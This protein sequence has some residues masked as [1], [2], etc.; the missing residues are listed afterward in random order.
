MFN[1]R[2]SPGDWQQEDLFD[3]D[4][5]ALDAI[6]DL[7]RLSLFCRDNR[8]DVFHKIDAAFLTSAT[9]ALFMLAGRAFETQRRMAARAEARDL[10]CVPAA[11][12]TFD[13]ALRR[14]GCAARRFDSGTRNHATAGFSGRVARFAGREIPTHASILAGVP[15]PN[16][17]VEREC[18]LDVNTGRAYR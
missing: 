8:S 4:G 1:Q 5:A 12:W 11:F 14:H 7:I 16:P 9:H 13:H 6:V 15:H 18:G 3:N 2:E 10:A 17:S